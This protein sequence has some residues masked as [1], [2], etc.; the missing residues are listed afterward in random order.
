MQM[1]EN[2][3][4]KREVNTVIK[5]L[6]CAKRVSSLLGLDLFYEFKFKVI[7]NNLE[8]YKIDSLIDQELVKL[9]K[10]V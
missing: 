7:S 8:K 5:V 10:E 9:L 3:N 1:I 6:I 2:L 4:K